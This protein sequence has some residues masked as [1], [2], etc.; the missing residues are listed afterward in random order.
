MWKCSRVTVQLRAK[1]GQRGWEANGKIVKDRK[2]TIPPMARS[3][4][5][6]TQAVP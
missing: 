4:V 2:M 6:Q 3:L 5:V 1:F